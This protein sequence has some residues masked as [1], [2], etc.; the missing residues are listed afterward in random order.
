MDNE[1]TL[2]E[3]QN[4][5]RAYGEWKLRLKTAISRGASEFSPD[6]VSQDNQCAFGKWL[7]GTTLPASAKGGASYASVKR[8]HAEFH[9]TA[10]KVLKNALDGNQ[11]M[12]Q[13]LL[14]GDFAD[15][16]KKLVAALSEW[17]GALRNA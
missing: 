2:V 4:A 1:Q 10:G 7:H 6:T 13:Q 5:I 3:I 15:Q 14:D 12:S 11:A 9:Q 16:S 17:K 8:M